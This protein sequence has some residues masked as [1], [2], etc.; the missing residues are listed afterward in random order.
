MSLK[1]EGWVILL[2]QRSRKSLARLPLNEQRRIE[3]FLQRRLLSLPSPRAVGKS[4][5]GSGP[6]RWRYRVGD[7]RLLALIED[8]VITITIIEIGHRRD[9]YR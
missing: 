9:V 4:L 1:E 2:D 7:Y 5:K 3:T 6:G 8:R